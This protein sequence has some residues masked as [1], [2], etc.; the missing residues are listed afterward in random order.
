MMD[1][2][3]MSVR[4]W[5]CSCR[6]GLVHIHVYTKVI[7]VVRSNIELQWWSGHFMLAHSSCESFRTLIAQCK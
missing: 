2:E 3:V 4:V 5:V 6:G 7:L 1:N